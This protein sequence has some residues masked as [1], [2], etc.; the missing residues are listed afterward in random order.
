M[1]DDTWQRYAFE[2]KTQVW[3]PSPQAVDSFYHAKFTG[4]NTYYPRTVDSPEW[5]DYQVY[6]DWSMSQWLAERWSGIPRTSGA[7]SRRG[8]RVRGL[9]VGKR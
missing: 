6:P 5:T 1:E 3:Q 9:K 7:V 4:Q 8:M 2:V